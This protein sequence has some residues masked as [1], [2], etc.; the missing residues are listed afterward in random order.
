MASHKQFAHTKNGSPG[1]GKRSTAAPRSVWKEHLTSYQD[2]VLLRFES[3]KQLEGAI[4]LLWLDDLRFLPHE[5]PDGRSIA[6]P[7]EAADYFLRAGL[8]FSIQKLKSISELTADEIEK[9]RR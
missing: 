8:K 4:D 6:I 2:I 3:Q 1:K 7:A 9:L 5:T